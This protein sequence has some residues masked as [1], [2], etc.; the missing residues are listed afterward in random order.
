[1]NSETR[2]QTACA[3]DAG[4]VRKHNEDTVA[5]DNHLGLLVLA[6]GMG[7]YQAGEV[8]SEIAVSQIMRELSG[9]LRNHVKK[10]PDSQIIEISPGRYSLNPASFA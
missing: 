7:G 9:T 1:M 3:T 10:R 5:V 8:A 6:D 4:L 2:L